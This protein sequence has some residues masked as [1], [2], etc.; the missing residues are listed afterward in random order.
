MILRPFLSNQPLSLVLL[1]PVITGFHLLNFFFPYH[2]TLPIIDLGLWGKATHVDE[3]W[4]SIPTALM[5]ALNAFQITRLF[6]KHEFLERYNYGPSLFYVVLMSFSH[7]FY[8]LDG[9]LFVHVFLLQAIRILFNTRPNEDHRKEAFNSFFF[10]GLAATFLTPSAG[11]VVF[12]WFAFWALKSFVFRE[13]IMMLIGF[14]FPV[15]NALMYWWFSGH[16]I[17]FNVLRHAAFIKNETLV[18]YATSA[19]VLILF[20]L[21]II[22]VQVRLQKSSIRFKKLNRSLVWI[23]IGTSLLG[24]SDLIIYQQVEWF[25]TIFIPLSFFFT[26]A[27]IHKFWKIVATWFFYATLLVAVVKFFLTSFPFL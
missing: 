12:F 27:F 6:N 14:A 10:I 17:G 5:V 20:V 24:I 18:Y 9:L 22:G 13:W 21:S 7:S 19:A 15:F 16:Q 2:T 25:N 11:L 23:L 1:I 8:Q 4:I 26:F 3:W